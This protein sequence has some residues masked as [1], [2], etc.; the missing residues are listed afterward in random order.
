MILNHIRPAL[1]N[2]KP[3]GNHQSGAVRPTPASGCRR[4]AFGSVPLTKLLPEFSESFQSLPGFKPRQPGSRL[5]YRDQEAPMP[6]LFA[7]L[8]AIA[9]L[10]LLPAQS[11]AG[12]R[13]QLKLRSLRTVTI[14]VTHLVKKALPMRHKISTSHRNPLKHRTLQRHE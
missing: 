13:I 3:A 4:P 5:L 14:R 8:I 2:L 1:W 6:D 10:A 12:V 11:L 7:P 9:E